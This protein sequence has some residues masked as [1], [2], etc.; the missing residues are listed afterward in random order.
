MIGSLAH[1]VLREVP[2]ELL[3]GVASGQYRVAGSIIQ[4]V[5]SGRVVGHLQETSAISSLLNFSPLSLPQMAIDAVSVVQN[6]QIKAAISIVQ[7]LQIANLVASGMG[8]GVSVAGAAILAKRIARVEEKVDAI[9]PNLAAIVRGLEAM[10]VERITE[11]FTRLRTLVGQVEEAW[12]PS[13]SQREWI[14]IARDAHFLADSFERR[15]RELGAASD[16]LN[17]EPLVE[18]FALASGLRVTARMASCQDDMAREAA[19]SRALTLVQLG[20][21]IQLAPL[22]LAHAPM[23]TAGTSTWLDLLGQKAD[24]LRSTVARVR[25][26]EIAAAGTAE[27]L[28]ELARQGV[29]GREWLDTAKSEGHNPLL[30]LPVR[31]VNAPEQTR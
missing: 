26:R 10:R 11:D 20:E 13:A 7:S 8:I 12:L 4:S 5:S 24:D 3:A 31:D 22:A 25:E 15:A 28:H 6:E 14:A 17:T 2:A 19:S 1:V 21:A 16:V 30:F 27:T 29:S 18:A 23:E 9:L